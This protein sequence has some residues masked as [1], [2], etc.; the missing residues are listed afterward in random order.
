MRVVASP[1]LAL[2][3]LIAAGCV[4]PSGSAGNATS[5]SGWTHI[6]VQSTGKCLDV[7]DFSSANGAPVQQW[8]CYAN[9]NQLW[10]LDSQGG[11]QYR[12]VSKTSG[13]CLDI[14]DKSLADGARVQ[15]WECWN[16]SNQ[17][18]RLEGRRDGLTRIVSVNSS[19][20]LDLRDGSP[21][22]GALFQQWACAPGNGNQLFTIE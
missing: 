17:L 18:F 16:A 3:L 21:V 5:G 10:S 15:Q 14:A 9:E 8:D 2:L 20:C 12:I 1:G 13:K 4:L 11:G 6:T 19:K 7:R 22:N